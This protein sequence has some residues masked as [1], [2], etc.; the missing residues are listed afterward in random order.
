MN[1]AQ[2]GNLPQ[3]QAANFQPNSPNQANQV[4]KICR[5]CGARFPPS[6]KF[7]GRCGNS[8]N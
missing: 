1:I 7:C 6:I 3:T 4:E 2:T 8:L 5:R